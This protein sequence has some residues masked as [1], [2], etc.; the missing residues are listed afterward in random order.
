M[1]LY[2]RYI[3]KETFE[4]LE[5]LENFN[6]YTAECVAVIWEIFE[7]RELKKAAVIDDILLINRRII[8]KKLESFNPLN[9]KLEIHESSFLDKKELKALYKTE[10]N[11]FIKK[12]NHFGFDVW[13]Y[14]IGGL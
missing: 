11:R 9:E 5:I 10:L 2:E 4:L 1:T 14:A 12:Q 7:F 13:S 3:G 8:R 6:N